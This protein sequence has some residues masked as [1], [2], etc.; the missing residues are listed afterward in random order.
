MTSFKPKKII[1]S[2]DHPLFREALRQAVVSA[3]GDV[4]IISVGGFTEL[5]RTMLEH[6]DCNLILLDLHMPGAVG[7]S[8]L[9]YLG[10]RYPETPV[11]MVSANEDPNV[12]RRSLEYGASG[13]IPKSSTMQAI[14]AA[15]QSIL[16]GEIWIPKNF[17]NKQYSDP[18]SEEFLRRV[19]LL[20]PSQFR[21]L[22]M[23][24]DGQKNK[25]MAEELNVS[26]ATVKAHLSEIFRKLEVSN[27]TQA[28]MIAATHLQVEDPNKFD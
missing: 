2:D 10:I 24:V 8:A 7:F 6:N 11:V 18:S 12:V 21:V 20:T 4:E 13:F 15:I 25:D 17:D 1:I 3:F 27:R 26:E 14:V 22:M 19:A 5:Q 16:S 9:Q 23:L 28:A